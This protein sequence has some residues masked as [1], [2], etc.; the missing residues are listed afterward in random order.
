M[1]QT[2]KTFS[3]CALL[4]ALPVFAADM[5]FT[6]KQDI[7]LSGKI[8]TLK[9]SNKYRSVSKCQALCES[10][11]SCVAFSFD[12]SKGSCKI[13]KTITKETANKNVTSG[14]KS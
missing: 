8:G 11:T 2:I 3:M 5:S 12:A 9:T 10:R 1:N 7:S 4:L 6:P 13:L 14:V